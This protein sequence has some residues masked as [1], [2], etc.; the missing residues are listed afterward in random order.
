V[1]GN[2]VVNAG[3]VAFEIVGSQGCGKDTGNKKHTYSQ[4]Q[5]Y[6]HDTSR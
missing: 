2:T 5:W 4:T 3:S 6:P 1:V